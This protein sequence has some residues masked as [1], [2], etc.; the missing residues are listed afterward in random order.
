MD[1]EFIA[2]NPDGSK[3]WAA[4]IG[5]VDSKPVFGADGTVYAVVRDGTLHALQ[6]GDGKEKWVSKVGITT[7]AYRTVG[8]DGTMYMGNGSDT[9]FAVKPNGSIKW[10]YKA[11]G[12]V[13]TDPVIGS[14]GTIY[15]G[16]SDGKLYAINPNG[17]K[18]WEYA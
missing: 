14:D 9:L 16:A 1:G 18:K 15:V 10:A 13:N 12:R 2:V 5:P 11:A 6:P 17:T 3:K 8:R 7:T 4:S